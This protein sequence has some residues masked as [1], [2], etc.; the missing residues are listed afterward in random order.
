MAGVLFRK[1]LVADIP[2]AWD[3]IVQAKAQMAREDRCQWDETY[4]TY[5]LI[6]SDVAAGRGYVLVEDDALVAYGVVAFDGEPAYQEIEG[7]WLSSQP[8]VVVHRLAVAQAAQGRGF[9]TCF[10]REA[11]RLARGKGVRSFRIDTNYDNLAML[12]VIERAGFTFCGHIRY[13]H[14]RRQAFEKC[15]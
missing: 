15:I 11:E 13:E 10:L 5:G 4:P 7:A 9:A 2:M 14:G 8:Y 3:I 6:C 1:A 12:R